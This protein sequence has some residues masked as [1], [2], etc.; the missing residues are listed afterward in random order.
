MPARGED[1]HE[2]ILLLL[3]LLHDPRSDWF[4]G[5]RVLRHGVVAAV[6][7]LELRLQREG[8]PERHSGVGGPKRPSV[9]PSACWASGSSSSMPGWLPTS[10]AISGDTRC[11]GP[12]QESQSIF[13]LEG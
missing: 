13:S 11:R 9:L 2:R 8:I 6:L 5:V 10:A 1:G 4:P 7:L 12:P 3:A